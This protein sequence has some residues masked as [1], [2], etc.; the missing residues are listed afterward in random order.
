MSFGFGST[1]P[2]VRASAGGGGG[3]SY[4][5]T[6]FV[7]ADAV[8]F[9]GL[10]S[11]VYEDSARTTPIT[12]GGAQPLGGVDNLLGRPEY[13]K[14]TTSNS[15][16][17][18]NRDS[19]SGVKW[20]EDGAES[21]SRCL[22]STLNL[23]GPF[24]LACVYMQRAPWGGGGGQTP[25]LAGCYTSWDSD[26]FWVRLDDGAVRMQID[27]DG[28]WLTNAGTR[29]NDYT[30]KGAFIARRNSDGDVRTYSQAD[31]TAALPWAVAAGPTALAGDVAN[32]VKTS[33]DFYGDRIKKAFWFYMAADIS[34]DGLA[35]LQQRMKDIATAWVG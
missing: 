18:I 27:I 16:P 30:S 23:S 12:W 15:R 22:D 11:T 10:L 28:S 4:P 14:Q 35:V 1:L 26:A 13:L 8:V 21:Y 25:S 2:R 19:E 33:L 3:G 20:F 31:A 34:E 5:L 6:P 29:T 17:R 7:T 24:T 9:D 32:S